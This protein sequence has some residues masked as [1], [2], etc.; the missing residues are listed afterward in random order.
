[1]NPENINNFNNFNYTTNTINGEYCYSCQHYLPAGMQWHFHA[2]TDIHKYNSI[3]P[4]DGR[5]K[6]IVNGYKG[7][8]L[9]YMFENEGADESD[10]IIG[11]LYCDGVEMRIHINLLFVD[12]PTAGIHG[13]YVWIKN[14]SSLL[15]KQLG[16][17]RVKRWFC[18]Q[19]LQ[20]STS[21]ERAAQHTLRCSRV[22]TEGPRK[23]Q[24]I[25][26][27]NHHRQL[28][29]PFV[30]YADF[31]CILE[32]VSLDVSVNTKIINKHV[33]VAFAYYIKCAFDS[34]LDKFVSKTGG[35]VART[36][37]KNLT[38]DLSDLYENHMKIV[39][40][41]HMTHNELDN[42]RKATICH[43]C[44]G[45][46][47]NDRVKDHCHFTGRYR[48]AAHNS[49]NLNYKTGDFIPVFFHNFSKY[50]SHL[51]VKELGEIEGEIKVIPLNKELYISI[52]K[53]LPLRKNTLEIRF[54]DTIRFMPSSL[55]TLAGN[56]S[57]E[58]FNVLK[59]QYKN[60]SDFELLRRKGVF[61]YEYLDSVEKLDETSLPPRSKFYSN[62]TES[63]CSEEDYAHAIQVWYHFNCR[64]LKEYLELYLKTDVL[65]LT[66]VFQ[67]FR[68]IC[69]SIYN[70]DPAHYY[71]T[72]GLKS[73]CNNVRGSWL[74]SELMVVLFK[75]AFP[76]FEFTV[77][78]FVAQREGEWL[79][80][81]MNNNFGSTVKVHA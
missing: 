28:E 20:Y 37:I 32:P 79:V 3:R 60:K 38:S 45:I 76:P 21:E 1:M 33:P 36:F 77:V 54:L 56:L 16:K 71:T 30:V 18:N 74:I 58:N 4:V 27:K 67:N 42:F 31:E 26:F 5:I 12:G 68:A 41:M 78:V 25:S 19:C 72:P 7:R 53:Y 73:I 34:G 8:I 65:L 49:C 61:P 66:D 81:S 47:N 57:E 50:D 14:I 40:P 51:F 48:G 9:Q 59:S 69:S 29:V 24:K 44:K 70:L 43:I 46:L 10:K 39:V 52:S 2:S 11:P 64:S 75:V 62:L 17:H 35:D 22:V 13:H 15:A 23:D 80:I 6:Q 55:D 63:E